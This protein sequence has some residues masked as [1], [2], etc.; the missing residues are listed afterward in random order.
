VQHAQALLENKEQG[1]AG[2][3]DGRGVVALQGRLGEFEEPVADL[4]PDELVH[5]LRGEIEAVGGELRL[6]LAQQLLQ[7][8]EDPALG[9]R[10]RRG[11]ARGAE[12]LGVHQHEARGVPQLVAEVLVTL[13]AGEVELDVAAVRGQRG[14]GEAQG[15]GAEGRD[16]LGELLARGF[17]DL[18]RIGRLHQ[19]AGALGNERL[20][21]DT[22]DEIDRIEHIALR[23]RHLLAV[24]V[25]DE[26]G[27][28]DVL[29][30]HR[31]GEVPGHHD[32]PGDPEE[33]DVEAGDQHRRRQV[34]V[35]SA[36]CHR[37]RVRPAHRRVR[38]DRRAE[39][40]LQHIAVLAQGDLR[41]EPVCGAHLGLVAA[42]VDLS[43]LVVPRR[44]AV[45]PPELSADAPVLDVLQPVPVGVDPVLGYEAHA[46]RRDGLE[47]PLREFVHPHEPLVREVGLDD[48]PGAVAARDHQFVRLGFDQQAEGFQLREYPLTRLEA[49]EADEALGRCI[50]EVRGVGEQVDHRQAVALADRVIVEVVRRRDLD[51]PGAEGAVD[52]VVGDDRDRAVAE[53]QVHLPADEVGVARVL[54]VDHHRDVAQHRL[55]AGGGDHQVIARFAQ[56]LVAVGVHLDMLVGGIHQRVAD[57]PQL[58]AFLLA[59]DFEV[60]DRGLQHRVPVDQLLAAVDEPLLVQLHES[61][62]DGLG[63]HR[64]HGE[65]AARPVARAAQAAHL[66]LDGVAGFPLPRPDLLDELLAAESVAGLALAGQMEIP[67]DHHLGGDAGMVGAELPERVEAAHAV[68]ADE[69][70]HQRVLEGVAHVQRAGDVRRRQQDTVG[71]LR[72]ITGGFEEAGG[73]PV[74]VPFRFEGAGLEAL[75]HA[76]RD[77]RFGPVKRSKKGRQA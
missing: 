63:R 51:H 57:R 25:A 64:V 6:H 70:V 52:V 17:L 13:A 69:R 20:D 73:L 55:R 35:E 76:A 14:E 40:G 33:E 48:L 65:D 38:P 24:L 61:L 49:V 45:A 41:A 36:L 10:R 23:L 2:R 9:V 56:G 37:L 32:H 62:D 26:A 34:A 59:H 30:G 4:V 1:V 43:G 53:R 68:V 5:G 39:P 16:A 15:I 21:A 75:V 60:G 71:G 18:R 67:R 22:V 8:V 77:R 28:V 54:G 50:V 74:G 29:E 19:A 66:A 42:D 44:D 58:A 7:A 72:G 46:A 12:A 11:Q 27:D 3:G 31:A 47:A